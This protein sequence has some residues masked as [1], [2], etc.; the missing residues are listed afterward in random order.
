MVHLV[1]IKMA[2]DIPDFPASQ[3]IQT[4]NKRNINI[5]GYSGHHE[6]RFFDLLLQE[7]DMCVMPREFI[8]C[9]FKALRRFFEL[10]LLER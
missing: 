10:Y 1:H 8:N 2:K 6:T 3:N 9:D 7:V 4:H 5:C